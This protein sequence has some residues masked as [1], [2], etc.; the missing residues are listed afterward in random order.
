MTLHKVLKDALRYR[1]KQTYT[2]YKMKKVGLLEC[3]HR[4]RVITWR[5]GSV[6][7]EVMIITILE[8]YDKVRIKPIQT[9]MFT[10]TTMMT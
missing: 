2:V 10:K 7:M 3:L 8:E 1:G 6:K 4:G 9:T 5:G